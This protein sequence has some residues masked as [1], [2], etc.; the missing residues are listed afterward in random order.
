MA[1]HAFIDIHAFTLN[2][3]NI[4]NTNQNLT[5]PKTFETTEIEP[6]N[7]SPVNGKKKIVKKSS[8]VKKMDSR[9]YK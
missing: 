2:N 4:L 7:N 6:N 8:I 9:P 3:N 1:S 5:E